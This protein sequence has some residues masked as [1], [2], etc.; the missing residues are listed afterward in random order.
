MHT[1]VVY[2]FG[3]MANFM[4]KSIFGNNSSGI[5]STIIFV[6]HQYVAFHNKLCFIYIG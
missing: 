2:V 3:K 6:R 5:Q 4:K 1:T